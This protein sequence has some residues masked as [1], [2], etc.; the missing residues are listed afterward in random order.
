MEPIKR[1]YTDWSNN[2]IIDFFKNN[3]PIVSETNKKLPI[4]LIGLERRQE[5]YYTIRKRGF[6]YYQ[7]LLVCADIFVFF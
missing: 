7:F 1:P 2:Q 6:L 3:F 4:Y 5:H